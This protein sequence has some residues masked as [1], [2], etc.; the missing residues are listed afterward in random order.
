MDFHEWWQREGHKVVGT[1][2]EVAHAAFNAAKAQSGN[3]VA[4]DSTAARTVTFA[5]GRR[6]SAF[7]DGTLGVGWAETDAP[8]S[9]GRKE[10]TD[11]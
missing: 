2:K 6:V 7:K 9:S 3:Y 10:M 5:N 8:M 11:E 1:L 4:D